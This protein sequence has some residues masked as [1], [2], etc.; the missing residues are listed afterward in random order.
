[1]RI[2]LTADPAI[3]VPPTGYGG[4][5]RIVDALVRAYRSKGHAVGL[6]SH[7]DSSCGADVRFAWPAAGDG[8]PFATARNSLALVRAAMIFRPDVVHSFSRLGYLLPLLPLPL[9]KVMS[10]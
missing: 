1:M 8:T 5:E 10:Y 7:P 4:I 9:P 2:L 6:L 3:P